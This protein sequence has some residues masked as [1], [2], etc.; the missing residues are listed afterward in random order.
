M[1]SKAQQ[2]DL[3]H[4]TETYFKTS[5]LSEDEFGNL[6]AKTLGFR[7]G[8]HYIRQTRLRLGLT[9]NHFYSHQDYH[10]YQKIKL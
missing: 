3:E 9:P 2:Y 7:P 6:V 5:G 1:L 4:F 10:P 8:K